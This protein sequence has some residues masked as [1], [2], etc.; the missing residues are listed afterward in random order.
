MLLIL[1]LV[2]LQDIDGLVRE[3][4][5]D[6]SGVREKAVRRLLEI[7]PAAKGALKA[8]EKDSDAEL[9]L[10]VQAL[11]AE[12]GRRE[13]VGLLNPAPLKLTL[14][15]KDAPVGDALRAVFSPYGLETSFTG[16]TDFVNTRKVSLELKDA[17]FWEAFDTLCKSGGVTV[18]YFFS[19]FGISFQDGQG[20]VL[21]I[22]HSDIGDLRFIMKHFIRDGTYQIQVSVVAPPAYRLLSQRM[23]DVTYVDDQGRP[24][25]LERDYEM[26]EHRRNP[27]SLMVNGL[28]Q[29]RRKAPPDVAD[30]SKVEVKGTLVRTV[31]RDLERFEAVFAGEQKPVEIGPHGMTLTALWR[32]TPPLG[33]P[34]RERW[35][36]ELAWKNATLKKNYLVWVE[37]AKGRWL[38]DGTEFET[39]TA[40]HASG[41]KG[42]NDMGAGPTPPGR[43]VV[44]SVEGRE[45]IR[46]PFSI[47]GFPGPPKGEN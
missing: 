41:D 29:G 38:V 17:L 26:K 33:K 9:R 1:A 22:P 10:R 47:R 20:G 25:D 16:R 42:F 24:V 3:L 11:L 23:V 4:G 14:S 34:P 46:I 28:S 6:D 13:R 2:A 32:Q 44:V 5:D 31:P 15:L 39:G 36:V 45:E 30:W 18:D 19:A 8:R 40:D 43:L 7:G 37:D 27:G 12:I 21:T 35:Q